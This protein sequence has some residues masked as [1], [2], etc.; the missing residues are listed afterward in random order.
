[1]N[2]KCNNHRANW[3][4]IMQWNRPRSRAQSSS[5]FGISTSKVPTWHISNRSSW[6]ERLT[7]LK[8]QSTKMGKSKSKTSPACHPTGE[9]CSWSKVTE[10]A[11]LFPL[12]WTPRWRSLSRWSSEIVVILF[13]GRPWLLKRDKRGFKFA[14][15]RLLTNCVLP[16]VDEF[17]LGELIN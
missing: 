15:L 13:L 8:V 6:I 5:M 9:D 3:A 12:I 11:R 14:G 16:F 10:W 7:T 17:Q 2:F 4:W 1:M